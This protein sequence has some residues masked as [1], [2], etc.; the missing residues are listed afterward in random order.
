MTIQ[1][2]VSEFQPVK[3][4]LRLYDSLGNVLPGSE[5]VWVRLVP[6]TFREDKA[7]GN[8]IRIRYEGASITSMANPRVLQAEDIWLTFGG[9]NLEVLVPKL[10]E[11]GEPVFKQ[12]EDGIAYPVNETISFPQDGKKSIAREEFMR[13]L[14]QLPEFIVQ[15]WHTLVITTVARDWAFPF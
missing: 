10:D 5:D 12:N 1:V 13:R 2:E 9:T 6:P 7:R 4:Q 15:A 14:D 11:N 3:E 8:L